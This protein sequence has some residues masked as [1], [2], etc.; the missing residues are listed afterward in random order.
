MSV[1]LQATSL[2]AKLLKLLINPGLSVFMLGFT[3]PEPRPL[4]FY[5]SS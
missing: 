3:N 5:K 2:K 4:S 1:F